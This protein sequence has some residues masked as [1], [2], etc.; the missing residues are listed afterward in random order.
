MP[1]RNV[2]KIDKKKRWKNV[3]ISF[4]PFSLGV[5]KKINSFFGLVPA[6]SAV[7]TV[8]WV[9]FDSISLKV[10]LP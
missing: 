9:K 10:D 5:I 3:K 2:Q 4:T 6:H 7:F 8:N 1:V